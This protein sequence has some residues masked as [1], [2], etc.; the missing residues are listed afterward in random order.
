MKTRNIVLLSILGLIVLFLLATT[1]I[2]NIKATDVGVQINKISNTID[3]K[4]LP[5]GW[6]L[7]NRVKTSIFVYRVSARSFPAD[8]LKSENAEEYTLE[9]KT[10]DG[11]EIA[12]DLTMIYALIGKDVPKLHIDVGPTFE[13]DV[14]LPQ[15]RSEGR[16]IIGGFQ[17]EEIYQGN[18]RDKIQLG[19]KDKLIASL[20]KYPAIEVRDV[21]IRAFAFKKEFQAIV[22]NKKL[23]ATKI[24]LNT[25]LA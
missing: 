2:R 16:I 11:Q 17:A 9:L 5:V 4:P 24:Q 15:L 18:V 13:V 3:E 21:L 23:A 10:K 20:S 8:V 19:I 7:Y 14:L 22:E 6:H 12:V 25:N 1:G